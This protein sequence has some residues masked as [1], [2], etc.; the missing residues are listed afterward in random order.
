MRHLRRC[1]GPKEGWGCMRMCEGV[2]GWAWCG[3][4][5]GD[6]GEWAWLAMVFACVKGEPRAVCKLGV[7]DGAPGE[8]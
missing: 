1:E 5:V 7:V 2:C 4:G 3:R 6:C 8:R